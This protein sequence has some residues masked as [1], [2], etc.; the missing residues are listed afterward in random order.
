MQNFAEKP[1]LLSELTVLVTK[2]C[3]VSEWTDFVT[4][5]LILYS[6]VDHAHVA[7]RLW[8]YIEVSRSTRSCRGISEESF[9]CA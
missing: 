6:I 4:A 3:E 2:K 1:E 5:T 8:A 7:A 9:V